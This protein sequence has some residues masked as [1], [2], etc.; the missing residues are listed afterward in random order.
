MGHQG[1]ADALQ[2]GENAYKEKVMVHVWGHLHPEWRK[3]YYGTILFVFGDYGD[4]IPIK[5]VFGGLPHSPWFFDDMMEFIV[6]KCKKEG[7][8]YKFT[9]FYIKFKN[10]RCRFTGE[11]KRVKLTCE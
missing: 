3:K 4:I 8:I 1:L 11:T 6:N 9:G 10:G 2:S 5:A 7:T